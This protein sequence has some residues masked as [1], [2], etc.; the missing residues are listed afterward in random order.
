M[1]R[2]FRYRAGQKKA[3]SE[4]YIPMFYHRHNKTALDIGCGIGTGLQAMKGVGIEQLVG[5]DLNFDRLR[6]ARRRMLD[7]VQAD[8]E[9]LPFEGKFG[10]IW[11]S[12]SFEHVHDPEK[13][14]DEIKRV[15]G[16]FARICFIIPYP[17]EHPTELHTASKA[18]G[19]H[20]DD[21]AVTL[22]KWFEDRGLTLIYKKF[23]NYREK[24]VW[25]IYEEA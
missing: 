4:L 9:N 16:K 25:M 15:I 24:E 2:P 20:I 1:K 22:V 13:A 8:M 7:V 10:I 17:D 21:G 3:I 14:L 12:H 18:I 23:D 5:I 11:S 19:A 6:L